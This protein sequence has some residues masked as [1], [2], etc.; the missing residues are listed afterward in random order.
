MTTQKIPYRSRLDRLAR[1]GKKDHAHIWQLQRDEG[2][3]RVY[4]CTLCPETKIFGAREK[5][6]KPHNYDRF[7]PY[8]TIHLKHHIIKS[9]KCPSCGEIVYGKKRFITHK[10]RCEKAK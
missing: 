3:Y 2:S 9:Y 1:S 8:K 5:K 10:S 7:E 4:R 6:K